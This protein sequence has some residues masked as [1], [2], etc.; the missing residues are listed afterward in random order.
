MQ[1]F[2]SPKKNIFFSPL[3][4]S[5]VMTKKCNQKNKVYNHK[6]NKMTK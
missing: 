4:A 5:I 3:W 2:F 6:E 1:E